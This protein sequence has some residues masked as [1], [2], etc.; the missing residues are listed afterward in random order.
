MSKI[1]S[2][3][4]GLGGANSQARKPAGWCRNCLCY[5]AACLKNRIMTQ[6]INKILIGLIG[7]LSVMAVYLLLV[8][9]WPEPSIEDITKHND[10]QRVED[11]SLFIEAV[12]IYVGYSNAYLT[13][14]RN[15]PGSSAILAGRTL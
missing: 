8:S 12:H 15:L 11:L 9:V 5:S 6:V 7:S 2:K 4:K 13:H 10:A 3:N 1:R 14:C